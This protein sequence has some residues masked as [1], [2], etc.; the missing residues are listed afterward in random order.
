MQIY[1]KIIWTHLALEPRRAELYFK[2]HSNTWGLRNERSWT[3]CLSR[4]ADITSACIRENFWRHG[5]TSA[6]LTTRGGGRDGGCLATDTTM[7][8]SSKAV[9]GVMSVWRCVTLRVWRHTVE[10]C[11]KPSSGM[12]SKCNLE[13]IRHR[14]INQRGTRC[15]ALAPSLT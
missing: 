11:W 12:I 8:E 1:S 3:S 5:N 10:S 15:Q 6:T 14:V 2:P 4:R 13:Q 9:V 7:T